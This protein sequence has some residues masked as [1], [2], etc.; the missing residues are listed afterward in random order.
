MHES[1][2]VHVCV[3][4]RACVMHVYNIYLHYADVYG[5]SQVGSA[6]LTQDAISLI[7]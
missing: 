7:I 6:P 2:T 4:V 1:T 3:C 5:G